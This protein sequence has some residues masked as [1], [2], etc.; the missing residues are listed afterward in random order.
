MLYSYAQP[1]SRLLRTDFA[2]GEHR[3]LHESRDVLA[4]PAVSA[5]GGS[6]VYFH[7]NVYTVPSAGGDP[8]QLTFRE[9]GEATLPAWSRSENQI[10]YYNQ[11]TLHRLD[12]ET[13]ASDLV[14]DDFHW[15]SKNWLAVHGNKV[16]YSIRSTPPGNEQAMLLDLST[17]QELQL[18]EPI[19]PT[20]FSRNG[21]SLLGR[22]A[23]DGAIMTCEAPDFD[24][25]PL[26]H[27]GEMIWGGIPRW[28]GD[29]TRVF[30]RRG[31]RDKPGYAYIWVVPRDGGEPVR[32]GEIGPY[33]VRGR[34]EIWLVD[35]R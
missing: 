5:D 14:I 1:I 3:I 22:R 21:R 8:V 11:R 34:S 23:W 25:E 18:D 29:E 12:P 24:C 19:L 7:D 30:F 15:S 13:G 32:L 9:P 27:D 28:S 26:L 16:A 2:S 33:D 20:D 6:I 17:G 31:R 35:R 4:L 10:Y